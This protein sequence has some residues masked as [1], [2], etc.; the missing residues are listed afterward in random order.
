MCRKQQRATGDAERPPLACTPMSPPMPPLPLRPASP[1]QPATS[2]SL[3][4]V[5][6]HHA[7]AI[8][9]VL[10]VHVHPLRLD[11]KGR[12]L[13]PQ[14][15]RQDGQLDGAAPLRRLLGGATRSG[16][17]GDR[18]ANSTVARRGPAGEHASG[19][20]PSGQ[21]PAA[22]SGCCGE[23]PGRT[24]RALPT[25]RGR[26][27]SWGTHPDPAAV[28]CR[29]LA[30]H[31]LVPLKGVCQHSVCDHL[32]AQ[33]PTDQSPGQAAWQERCQL[34]RQL[35]GTVCTVPWRSKAG[36]EG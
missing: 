25:R 6:D 5:D 34:R 3:T 1:S 23:G 30:Q 31:S 36:A 20:P 7:L 26:L 22:G 9:R 24:Q 10:P 12:N 16:A 27:A 18:V 28:V 33:R 32:P 11:V 4:I 35:A 13:A 19:P 29:L 2:R 14:V 17:A 8:P 21:Q 15:P